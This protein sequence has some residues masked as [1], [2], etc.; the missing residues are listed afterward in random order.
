MSLRQNRHRASVVAFA[1]AGRGPP[2]PVANRVPG[3]AF[4]DIL[5]QDLLAARFIQRP[6]VRVQIVPVLLGAA[7]RIDPG[8]V[9]VRLQRQ[10]LRKTA[11]RRPPSE[12]AAAWASISPEGTI[13][14][15]VVGA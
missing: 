5:Y 8:D 2:Q 4:R 10:A 1:D 11:T 15:G 12:S 9:L 6:Q 7:S 14:I 3:L 13:A